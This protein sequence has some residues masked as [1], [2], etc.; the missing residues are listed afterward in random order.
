MGIDH[1][2][3]IR[4]EAGV[5]YVLSELV[6]DGHVYFPYDQL[7]G[8]AAEL[9]GVD[10]AVIE[11][12]IP[13]LVAQG[14]VVV[15]Q[16]WEDKPVYLTPL[17]VAEANVAKRLGALIASPSDSLHIDAEKAIQWVQQASGIQLASLQ[18]DAIRKATASK[19]LVITGGPGTGKTTLVNSLIKILEKAGQRILLASPTG[20]AAKR[21]AEVTGREAKTLHRL[22]EFSPKQG[23]FTRNEDNPLEADFIVVDESSMVDILLMNHLLKAIPLAA[24][25]ILVGDVD[26]LPSVG[27]GNV[28]KDIISSGAVETVRLTE[29]FRQ[30]QESLI[31][32]NAHRVNQGQFIT[33]RGQEKKDFYFIDR[34]DPDKVLETIKELCSRMLPKSFGLNP[35]EDIQVLTPMHRGT[36]GVSNINTQLQ[37]LLNPSGTELTYGGRREPLFVRI[38]MAQYVDLL[39]VRIIITDSLGI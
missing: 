28:L 6:N 4:A 20:R 16:A 25:L 32:V 19:T 1:S 24:R 33:N 5:V 2:S 27:P 34:E 7:T 9:L 8:K 30:A 39:P 3:Q 26:Q 21:L 36:V 18:Q 22:L 10:I 15:D 38:L 35:R 37:A 29:V 13:A 14:H 12:A 23:M 31:V 11:K 17:H